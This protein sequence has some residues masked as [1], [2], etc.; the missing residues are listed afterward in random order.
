MRRVPFHRGGVKRVI[1]EF[2]GR[3]RALFQ[4]PLG[5]VYAPASEILSETSIAADA[6]SVSLLRLWKSDMRE[7]GARPHP[8]DLMVFSTVPVADFGGRI[9]AAT[10]ACEIHCVFLCNL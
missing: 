6:E 2:R 7:N 1:E 9:D 8:A 5:F 4:V 10:L 3:P